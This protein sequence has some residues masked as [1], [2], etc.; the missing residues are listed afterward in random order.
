MKKIGIFTD[1]FYPI[2]GGQGRH[3]LEIYQ[4]HITTKNF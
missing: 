2:I 1:D 4:K 3:L